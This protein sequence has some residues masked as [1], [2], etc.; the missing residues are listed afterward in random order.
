MIRERRYV[1]RANLDWQANPFS[2]LRVGAEATR[3]AIDRYESDLA[4]PGDA[5][6]EHPE[7]WDI[8]VEHR[9][10]L[11]DLVFVSGLR[12]DSYSSRASR[13]FLLDT[14]AGSDAYG[15]Y[16]NLP[17]AAIYEDGAPVDGRPLVVTRS[18][19]IHRYLSPRLQVSFPLSDRT[20]FRLSYAHEVQDPDFALVLL[21]VNLG[22]LGAD[23]DFGKTITFEFGVRHAFSD[24]MV[25]DVAAYNR[26]NLAVA[27]AR[28][29][30]V[31]TR[32]NSDVISLTQVTNADFGNT[33]G[34]GRP[35][36]APFR[37]LVQRNHQLLLPG[38]EE[39]GI[40]STRQ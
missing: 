23:L 32:W 33:R 27:S 3:Y 40:R 29:R 14:I 38:R 28:T 34:A 18:D 36:R 17:G 25:L 1:G 15:T 19:R 31:K 20:S 30:R 35:A 12:Y 11:G 39:H 8:F 37:Q 9:L 10:D 16:V 5:Y 2:R 21:G 7:R 24:D 26:D 4:S 6:I 22:G 13:P